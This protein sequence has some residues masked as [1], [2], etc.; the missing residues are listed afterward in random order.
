MSGDCLINLELKDN[1]FNLTIY[2]IKYQS[3]MKKLNFIYPKKNI[4]FV[5][6]QELGCRGGHAIPLYSWSSVGGGKQMD[7]PKNTERTVQGSKKRG[8]L[9]KT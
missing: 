2:G 5:S 1:F 9:K 6:T 8:V 7:W 4:T 3:A